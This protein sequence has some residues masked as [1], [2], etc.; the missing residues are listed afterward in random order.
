MAA[1]LPLPCPSRTFY[2]FPQPALSTSWTDALTS[3]TSLTRYLPLSTPH[4]ANEDAYFLTRCCAH[5]KANA[6]THGK[7]CPCT[8][9]TTE[10]DHA[11]PRNYHQ[12]RARNFHLFSYLPPEIRELI[13][14]TSVEGS[15]KREMEFLPKPSARLTGLVLHT[16]QSGLNYRERRWCDVKLLRVCRESRELAIRRFGRPDVHTVP[17]DTEG[18]FLNICVDPRRSEADD[19]E[20]DADDSD[21]H[22]EGCYGRGDVD[23][24][25]AVVF[26]HSGR[27]NLPALLPGFAPLHHAGREILQRVRWVQLNLQEVLW[28]WEGRMGKDQSTVEAMDRM[29][30]HL[31]LAFPQLE[32]LTLFFQRGVE[33]RARARKVFREGE[34]D[35][36]DWR[37]LHVLEALKRMPSNPR[38]ISAEKRAELKLDGV[39][40]FPRLK[41][42]EL[43]HERR[44]FQWFPNPGQYTYLDPNFRWT[45]N[46]DSSVYFDKGADP[47]LEHGFFE[48]ER[49]WDNGWN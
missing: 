18:D 29:V 7:S 31:Q 3:A 20:V 40:P 23:L 42:L 21:W 27:R 43:Y 45:W 34:H 6:Y 10:S 12:N 48:D 15:R 22:C 1:N 35:I 33:D 5:C 16:A 13:W 14:L 36:Y 24:E 30:A 8:R 38:G 37:I 17:F 46:Q 47:V 11:V 19:G 44:F 26:E 41:R 49:Q 28:G 4:A 32:Y 39:I 2:T 9:C 25:A